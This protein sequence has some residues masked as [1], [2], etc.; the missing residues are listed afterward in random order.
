RFRDECLNREQL[1]TLTE[2]RVVIE[3]FR[4]E[5]NAERPHSSL[6]YLSPQRFVA[7]NLYQSQAPGR[8]AKPVRPSAWDCQPPPQSSHQPT[9]RTNIP[10]GPVFGTRSPPPIQ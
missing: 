10:P 1:W 7:E 5:Y 8:T 3:D 4:L 2:A 6:G 9:L